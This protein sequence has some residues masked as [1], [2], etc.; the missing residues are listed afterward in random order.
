VINPT[1]CLG[2]GGGRNV[3][4]GDSAFIPVMQEKGQDTQEFPI[5]DVKVVKSSGTSHNSL[6]IK[7]CCLSSKVFTAMILKSELVNTFSSSDT[8][9][10]PRPTSL[11]VR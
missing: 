4:L 9:A 7:L 11:A 8:A 6:Y 3:K 1:A 10:S 2:K 5:Y